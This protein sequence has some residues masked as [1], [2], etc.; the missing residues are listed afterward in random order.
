MHFTLRQDDRLTDFDEQSVNL[1]Q[2]K[3]R[4]KDAGE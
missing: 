4:A 3:Y 2:K 1:W